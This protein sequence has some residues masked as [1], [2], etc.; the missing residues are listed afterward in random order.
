[1]FHAQLL[2]AGGSDLQEKVRVLVNQA[3]VGPPAP[4]ASP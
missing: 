1:V 3:I 4:G 2:P